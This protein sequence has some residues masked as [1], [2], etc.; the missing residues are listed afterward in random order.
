M[1]YIRGWTQL[2]TTRD[3]RHNYDTEMALASTP[4][5]LV[6]RMNFLLFGGTMT[7]ASGCRDITSL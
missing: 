2:S 7:D 5:A 3:I 1:N 4:S 6:D